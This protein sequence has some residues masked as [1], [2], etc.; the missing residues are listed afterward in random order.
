MSLWRLL[1]GQSADQG[2]LRGQIGSSRFPRIITSLVWGNQ[3]RCAIRNNAMQHYHSRSL[4]QRSPAVGQSEPRH[5]L[6]TLAGLSAQCL[7][8]VRG[9]SCT[10]D[11]SWR[12]R[13]MPG[14]HKLPPSSI[15]AGLSGTT[16]SSSTIGTSAL[17]AQSLAQSSQ[18]QSL[19]LRLQR[20]SEQPCRMATLRATLTTDA[21]KRNHVPQHLQDAYQRKQTA[22]RSNAY[23]SAVA[24]AEGLFGASISSQQRPAGLP[25]Q[26]SSDKSES[27][28]TL[29]EASTQETV[30]EKESES[31]AHKEQV[32]SCALSF[33]LCICQK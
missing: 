11:H 19:S 12:R 22:P 27:G 31:L 21:A 25:Y 10:A 15:T 8:Q 29:A 2:R 5:Q 20:Q 16:R 7:K 9:F 28:G 24:Q 13:T 6:T 14:Q 17:P 1:P 32:I 26:R 23:S 30:A 4:P 33:Q 18:L 3:R